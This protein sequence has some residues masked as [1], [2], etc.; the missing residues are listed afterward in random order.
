MAGI[1]PRLRAI[2]Q[3][4]GLSLR[5]VEQR[6]RQI[7]GERGDLSYQVSA[8]WL[9][10]LEGDEHELTARKFMVLAEI[11]SIAT[12]GLIRSI[13]PKNE[14]PFTLDQLPSPNGTM[15]LIEGSRNSKAE[16][17]QPAMQLPNR[18]HNETTL[19]AAENASFATPYLRG[20]IGKLDLTLD[21]MIPPGSMVLIDTSKCE[22]SV[23]KDWTHEFQRPI[24]FCKTQNRY[25][26]GWCELDQDSQRP[27]LIP[28]PLSAASSRGWRP[29][30][31]QIL[32]RVVAV[33]IALERMSLIGQVDDLGDDSADS[34]GGKAL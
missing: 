2:R 22:I 29:A 34:T 11:Y 19:L 17:S 27:I 13:Y 3:R 24:Y 5:E 32:G 10:R 26:C 8:S 30:E 31:I 14:L 21:P 33:S 25:F 16:S 6:S 18:S 1:G 9:S 23:R 7:A 28:H 4:W 20:V 15:M 12:N